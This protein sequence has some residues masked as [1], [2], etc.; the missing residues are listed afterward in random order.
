MRRVLIDD[1][2]DNYL[3]GIIA[4]MKKLGLNN[5]SKPEALRVL[6][7]QNNERAASQMVRKRRSREVVFR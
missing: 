1:Y 6:I 5:I 7:R 3:N 2:V 4:N